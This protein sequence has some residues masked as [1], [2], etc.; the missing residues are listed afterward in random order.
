[1]A[2]RFF[3]ILLEYHRRSCGELHHLVGTILHNIGVVNLR[4]KRFD[5]ALSHFERAVRVRRGALGRDHPDVAVSL[6]KVG[7]VQLLLQKFDV[8]LQ[9]F[10]DALSVRRHAL[11]HLHPSTAKVYNNIGCVHVEFNEMKEAR[12]AFEAALDIQRNALC[13]QPNKKLLMFGAATTLCNLGC[14]YKSREMHD[15][16]IVVLEEAVLLQ[17]RALG[18][19]HYTVLA[20]MDVLA[21]SHTKDGNF[22]GA[23]RCYNTVYDRLSGENDIYATNQTKQPFD[24]RKIHALAVILYKMNRMHYKQN[25]VES[26]LDKLQKALSLM[27]GCEDDKLIKLRKKVEAEIG[28]LEMELERSKLE[29]V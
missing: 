22:G 4:A 21:D 9:S 2:L 29:W 26:S 6:V 8:A 7:I 11:G 12:R 28:Q 24:I 10:R 15:Q 19:S 16:A 3:E 18:L 17:E 5:D 25:D 1:M 23:L 20:T 14:L 27:N 13:H